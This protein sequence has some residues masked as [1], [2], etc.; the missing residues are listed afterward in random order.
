ETLE[1]GFAKGE[2]LTKGKGHDVGLPRSTRQQGEL[3]EEIAAAEADMAIRQA[4]L[5]RARGDEIA[6]VRPIADPHDPLARD[7]EARPQQFGHSVELLLR[8]A[9]EHV[10]PLD[11]P[12]RIE[13]QVEPRTRLRAARHRDATLEI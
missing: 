7:G 10:E 12:T 8:K 1:V 5:D 4:H 6:G 11:Q 3:A 13:T 2:Q 9:R